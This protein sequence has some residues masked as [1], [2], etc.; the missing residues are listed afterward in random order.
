MSGV[1]RGGLVLVALAL[2]VLIVAIGMGFVSIDQTREAELPRLTGG[3]LPGVEVKTPEVQIG[4][5]STTVEVPRVAVGTVEEK[6]ELP[7]VQ[8]K[9]ANDE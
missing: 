7:T 6:V 2:L 5:T 4:T 8:V 1:L 9:K 3:Q